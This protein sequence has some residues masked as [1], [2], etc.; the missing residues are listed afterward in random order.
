MQS[1]LKAQNVVQGGIPGGFA[2]CQHYPNATDPK[3]CEALCK[4]CKGTKNDPRFSFHVKTISLT[5]WAQITYSFR[6]AHKRTHAFAGCGAW[7][8]VIRGNPT[9]SGD[10]CLKHD[11]EQTC[12]K[13]NAKCTSGVLVPTTKCVKDGGHGSGG[14]GKGMNDVVSMLASDTHISVRLF[15]DTAV[16][17]AYFMGGRVAMT[18]PVAASTTDWSVSIG[19]S[20]VATLINATSWGM[21]S[22]YV[23]KEEVLAMPHRG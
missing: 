9:G 22:I 4:V 18:I 5:R 2:G 14:K 15:L 21:S 23:T 3:V 6:K 13:A 1:Q 12:P 11:G 8:Y 10:C 16:A 19:A 7:T 17:E 20:T